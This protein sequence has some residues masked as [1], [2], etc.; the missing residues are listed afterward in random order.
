M[1]KIIAIFQKDFK[2]GLR[3]WEILFIVLVPIVLSLF[4]NTALSPKG[5]SPPRVVVFCNDQELKT[6]LLNIER[7]KNI[8]FS[9]N[10]DEAISMVEKGKVHGA[11]QLPDDFIRKLTA[12]EKFEIDVVLD[13]AAPVKTAIIRAALKSFIDKYSAVVSPVK[14]NIKELRVITAKQKMLDL[15][16][17]LTI[18]LIGVSVIPMSLAEEKEKKTLDAV[19]LTPI[20]E[21][22]IIL[23]KGMWGSFLILI[24]AIVLLLLNNGLTGNNG[25]LAVILLLGIFSIVGIGLFIAIFSPTQSTASIVGTLVMVVLLVS[26]QAADFSDPIK[27][28]VWVLPGYQILNGIRKA[29]FF[30]S[31]FTDAGVNFLVLFGWIAVFLWINIYALKRKKL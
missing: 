6:I 20:S 3:N 5:F 9:Q 25:L 18:I 29:I 8:K 14:L 1:R 21:R 24:N 13:G 17:L 26:A 16:L 4:F 2:N 23:S 11:F 19:L 15:W 28:F 7:F 27:R 10:W 12:Q 30:K 31:G 22:E